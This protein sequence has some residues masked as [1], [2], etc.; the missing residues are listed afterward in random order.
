MNKQEATELREI[1]MRELPDGFSCSELVDMDQFQCPPE[2]NPETWFN[3]WFYINSSESEFQHI[4]AIHS[5]KDW[6]LLKRFSFALAMPV[7]EEL[8]AEMLD[9]V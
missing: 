1:I 8:I 2:C 7:K 9:N 3:P 4:M 6:E 5:P